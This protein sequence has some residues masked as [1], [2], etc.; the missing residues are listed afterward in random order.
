MIGT[1]DRTTTTALR[2]PENKKTKEQTS[3][4]TPLRGGG[5]GTRFGPYMTSSSFAQILP[6]T[7]PN[8]DVKILCSAASTPESHSPGILLGCVSLGESLETSGQT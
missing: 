3:P 5:G 4:K 1:K 8:I 2:V 7:L 6:Q